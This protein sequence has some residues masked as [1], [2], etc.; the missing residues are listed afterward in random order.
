MLRAGMLRAGA[1]TVRTA[2]CQRQLS[3]AATRVVRGGAPMG[4]QNSGPN[5][6]WRCARPRR[7]RLRLSLG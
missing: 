6:D 4:Q 2:G 7:G 5:E 1:R 3:L